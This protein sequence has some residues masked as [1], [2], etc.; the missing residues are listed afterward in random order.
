V[1]PYFLHQIIVID[2]E[3]K[4]RYCRLMIIWSTIIKDMIL[5]IK[6]RRMN[7]QREYQSIFYDFVK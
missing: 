4:D 5:Q 1:L 3:I 6:R 7:R 2:V